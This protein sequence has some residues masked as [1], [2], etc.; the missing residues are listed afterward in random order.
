M[1]YIVYDTDLQDDA[2]ELRKEVRRQL[3][4]FVMKKQDYY[5][6]ER[7]DSEGCSEVFLLLKLE[8]WRETEYDF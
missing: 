5:F 3:T 7:I 4:L 6:Q 1:N 2:Y 8:I